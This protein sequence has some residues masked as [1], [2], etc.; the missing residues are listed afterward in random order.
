MFVGTSNAFHPAFNF[1]DVSDEA[2]DG[3][4]F[5][6]ERKCLHLIKPTSDI[7]VRCVVCAVGVSGLILAQLFIRGHR[8][9]QLTPAGERLY[10]GVDRGLTDIEQA[11]ASIR[12]LDARI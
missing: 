2:P 6:V 9:V 4:G 11:I 5:V 3:V 12:Q 10:A 8:K 1:V 7:R